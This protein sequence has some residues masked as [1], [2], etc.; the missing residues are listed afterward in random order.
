MKDDMTPIERANALRHGQSVDR[1]PCK[2]MLSE[3]SCR[4][5]GI[6]VF[7][8]LHSAKLMSESQ[9]KAFEVLG[10]DG[11][12]IGPD[13][14]GLL[15]AMGI[16][17]LYLKDDRPQMEKPLLAA[18]QDLDH[19]Q[20]IDPEK[21]GRLPL[22]LEAMERT[23]ERIGHLVKIGSGISGPFTVAALMR[24][25]DHFLVDL[26]RN[27]QFAHRLIS[28]M[29]D[30]ILLYMQCAWKRGFSCSIGEP[31]ASSTVISPSHFRA[32]VKPYLRKIAKWQTSHTKKSF[33]LHICG[34]TRRIW[35]D[36]VD[37]GA[38]NLSLDNIVDLAEAKQCVGNQIA[39]SGNVPPVEVLMD[40]TPNEVM[41]ATKVCIQ[42][43]YDNPKGFTL[44][45]GCSVQINT[46]LENM[47]AMMEG[48]RIYGKMPVELED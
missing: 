4:F 29:T 23:Q 47:E 30:N 38:S 44:S 35:D 20:Y 8:Y 34:Q 33:S 14:N 10:H 46:P 2:P 13:Q 37:T 21:D 12:G 31:M 25:P 22:Y 18:I 19:L 43:G 26:Y 3:Y 11:V 48:V 15:E 40:G 1:I 5:L 41:E 24:G 27:Q 39:I 6:P 36:M 16:N 9:I 28:F 7:D 32:F 45:T 17:L 42:K